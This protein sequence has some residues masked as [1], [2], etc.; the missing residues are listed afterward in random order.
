M[1]GAPACHRVPGIWY[2]T[3][4][5][6]D[7]PSPQPDGAG[8]RVPDRFGERARPRALRSRI[9]APRSLSDGGARF[10]R[11]PQARAIRILGPCGLPVASYAFSTYAVPHAEARR[12]D[13][14]VHA[15]G[16]RQLH[17]QG[18]RRGRRAWA[19]QRGR[20]V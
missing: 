4:D 5:T 14:G 6:F 3:V 11:L 8:A 20:A 1:A 9:R 15:V 13:T 7:C 16:A 10:T 17:G 12:A 19:A 2:K 18:V